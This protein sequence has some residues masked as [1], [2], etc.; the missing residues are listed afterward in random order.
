MSQ[1]RFDAIIF[2]FDGVLV[3]SVDVKTRAFAALYADYGPTVVAQVVA[4]HLAH[5]GV[6]RFEKFRH[7]HHAFLGRVLLQEE[8]ED[9]GARFTSLV[10]E[11]VIAANWLPGAQEF[12]ESHHVCIPLFVASGTPEKELNRILGRRKMSHYF[13]DTAGAPSHK[14]EIIKGF[15][16]KY[17]ISPQRMLMVGDAMTDFIGANEAGTAFLGIVRDTPNP[18]PTG[19]QVLNDLS[20]LLSLITAKNIHREDVAR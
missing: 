5:G 12:L 19:T 13:L 9:L 11:A 15:G 17:N 6:S 10:E 4:Y 18:F 16:L 8:E 7:F 2:D 3:D 14:G 1:F 20:G